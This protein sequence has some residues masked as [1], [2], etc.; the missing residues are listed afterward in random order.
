MAKHS[1]K[2]I[3]EDYK[4]LVDWSLPTEFIANLLGISRGSAY[5]L[6]K[7]HFEAQGSTVFQETASVTHSNLVCRE[8]KIARVKHE[9]MMC[10]PCLRKF[11]DRKLAAVAGQEE[12]KVKASLKV[13]LRA[14]YKK[15]YEEIRAQKIAIERE[16]NVEYR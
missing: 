13:K 5:A 10:I 2:Q 9:G 12:H 6:R 11:H 14:D 15:R 3:V 16:V 8:C 7:A 4:D 1:I